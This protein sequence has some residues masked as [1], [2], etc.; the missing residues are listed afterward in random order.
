MVIPRVDGGS[1]IGGV[2]ARVHGADVEHVV[3]VEKAM[4]G[5]AVDGGADGDGVGGGRVL[6]G[7]GAT[8]GR[9]LEVGDGGANSMG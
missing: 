3:K 4:A 9:R 8:W 7:T 1:V 5:G 2:V 6:A